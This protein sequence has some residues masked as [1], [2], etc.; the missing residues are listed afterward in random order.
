ME[1]DT[2]L[3][4]GRGS[5]KPAILGSQGCTAVGFNELLNRWKDVA[6]GCRSVLGGLMPIFILSFF[7]SHCLSQPASFF[8]TLWIFIP[9]SC[10]SIDASSSHCPSLCFYARPQSQ[11]QIKQVSWD[12]ERCRTIT[13]NRHK[14]KNEYNLTGY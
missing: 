13:C 6:K 12:C 9:V 8:Q 2:S 1:E 3:P 4:R 7:F 5:G 11:T 14:S 10:P